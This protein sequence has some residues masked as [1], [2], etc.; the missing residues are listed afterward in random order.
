MKWTPALLLVFASPLLQAEPGAALQTLT[1]VGPEGR[2]NAEAGPAWAAVV[3]EGPA[4]LGAVLKAM[5]GA[6]P[7]A[8]NWLGSAAETIGDQALAAGK[9]LPVDELKTVILDV[10]KAGRARVTAFDLLHRA[11]GAAADALVPGFLSDPNPELRRSAVAKLLT[12]AKAAKEKAEIVAACRKALEG[13]TDADQVKELAETLEKNGE[14][15]NLP[16][17][18]G[19]L[20]GWQVIGPFDNSGRRGFDTV[21]P[22]ETEIKPDAAYPGKSGEVKWQSFTSKDDYGQIDFNKPYGL[23]KEVTGYATTTFDSATERTAEVRLGCK[24]AWKVWLNGQLLFSRDEY[25]RGAEID[26]YKLPCRL[27]AGKNTLLVKLCQNEQTET[28]T[29]EWQFQLRLSDDTG[30]A[31]L[32]TDRN[33]DQ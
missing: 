33:A 28:W 7:L 19:F 2:G 4:A 21:F 10:K 11:D 29:A 12:A 16:R 20:M 13:A 14:K 25:H 9:A 23:I 30:R 8:A 24:N 32:S 18:F 15:V 1:A 6:N 5:E 26:Q 22:P 27:K 3:K 17:H 31:L